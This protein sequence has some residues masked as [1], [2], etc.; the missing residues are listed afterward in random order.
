MESE[1]EE[2]SSLS[3]SGQSYNEDL[4]NRINLQNDIKKKKITSE[5]WKLEQEN[6]RINDGQ[7]D[8]LIANYLYIKGENEPLKE[9][10]KESKI[11]YDFDENLLKQRYEIRNLILKNNIEEAI[12]KINSINTQILEKNK[13]LLFLLKK[14]KLLDLIKENKVEDA[15]KYSKEVLLPIALLDSKFYEE[16]ENL[17]CYLAF[18]DVNEIPD[19][20]IFD[21]SQLEILANTANLIILDEQG[22]NKNNTLILEL[23]T[24]I[25]LHNMEELSANVEFPKIIDLVPFKLTNIENN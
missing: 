23:L 9:F 22:D 4:Q 3:L 1:P 12:N 6:F 15:L 18:E 19:K 11:A 14:Q 25:M 17:L 16:L 21:A 5:K 7:M 20:N 13:N 2:E 10:I 24:K 8:N